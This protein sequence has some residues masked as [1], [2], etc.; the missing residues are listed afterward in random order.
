MTR[1]A[2]AILAVVVSLSG[3]SQGADG[4]PVDAAPTS[5]TDVGTETVTATSTSTP[6]GVAGSSATPEEPTETGAS[7]TTSE[8][9]EAEAE[10]TEGAPEPTE[11]TAPEP[12]EDAASTAVPAPP[13][14]D[15]DPCSE[16]TLSRD[17][18]DADTGVAPIEC[19]QGWAY[20]YYVG[21]EGDNDFIA[22]RI[23][24]TWTYVMSLG[25]PTCRE[26]LLDRGAPESV[27]QV[28]LTCEAMPSDD[29]EA[30][31]DCV[32]STDVYG[33][34]NAVVDGLTCDEASAIWASA[35][36]EPS[37]DTPIPAADG[38]ECYAFPDDGDFDTAVAGMC[39]APDF[40]ASFV[41]YVTGR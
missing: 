38:W 19:E 32:I 20:A 11:E 26:E 5:V 22:E 30:S 27:V 17:L 18:V 39:D 41:L 8:S 23:S 7:A 21:G 9:E 10:P 1:V 3:C 2:G 14:E 15:G 16:A 25:S 29:D 6:D 33:P 31:V 40:S 34:T 36:G 12:T 37:W 35:V 24:G 4:D 28:V 13:T